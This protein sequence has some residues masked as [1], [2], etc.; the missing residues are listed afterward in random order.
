MEME[1]GVSENG[2][3]Y[4]VLKESYTPKLL[5]L[6]EIYA[7]DR[8][9]AKII[10]EHQKGNDS[11]I[12]FRQVLF[13]FPNGD[14]RFA[15]IHKKYG[16]SKSN[17]IYYREVTVSA[18]G[19]KNGKFYNIQSNRPCMLTIN[20]LWYAFGQDLDSFEGK[21]ML[22]R[23]GWI[24]NLV[25]DERCH[26]I[27][28]NRIVKG[29]MFTAKACLRYIY[30]V[31]FPVADMLS[32]NQQGY[33]PWD[34]LK[35]WKEMKKNLINIENLKA[36]LFNDKLF[37]DT[38]LMANA[39]GYKVN[40]S[41]SNKRLKAEHDK[42]AREMVDVILEFEELRELRISPVYHKFA[43]FSG[44]HIFTTNHELIEEGKMMNHC[45]GTYSG[46]VDAG[47]SCIYRVNNHT[48]ELNYSYDYS[49]KVKDGEPR[50]MQ[51]SIGQYMGYSNVRAPKE[52]YDEVIDMVNR[53]NSEV[54]DS[55]DMYDY[56]QYN[57]IEVGDPLPF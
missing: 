17:I 54:L 57:D 45:V 28:L 55:T 53:F 49:H 22:S 6:L 35:M 15:N 26:Y 23:Y 34:F 12:R 48:L 10:Y 14:F 2:V 11:F 16:V 43:E 19:I 42:M 13:E 39:L 56:V 33:N 41:W 24:R 44:Y 38:T 5:K 27:D 52:L 47:R 36:S 8:R 1:T 51:L 21:F 31:P 29:K 32:K 18:Y 7:I 30:K 4:T 20:N 9:K 46:H 37:K 50:R 3:K 40:C 25:E